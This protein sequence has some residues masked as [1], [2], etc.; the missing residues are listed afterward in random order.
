MDQDTDN[1]NQIK[2]Q[3]V[4]QRGTVIKLN[5]L[6]Y[7]LVADTRVTGGDTGIGLRCDP[8]IGNSDLVP[9]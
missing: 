7:E 9:S 3:V 8:C 1:A 4:L 2:E 5:G 6:P